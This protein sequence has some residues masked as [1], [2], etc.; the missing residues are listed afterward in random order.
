MNPNYYIVF[1][2]VCS[3]MM[4]CLYGLNHNE[5][6]PITIIDDKDFSKHYL[7][8][9]IFNSIG[10]VFVGFLLLKFQEKASKSESKDENINNNK[11]NTKIKLIYN[12]N[13]NEFKS[14]KIIIFYCLIILCWVL[15]DDIIENY[16]VIFQDLDFWMIELIILSWLSKKMFKYQLYK[17]HLLSISMCIFSSLLKVGC[18][19]ITFKNIGDDNDGKN[20]NGNLPIFYSFSSPLNNSIRIILAITFYFLLI[21]I[22]SYISLKLKWLMEKKIFLILNYSLFM[23]FQV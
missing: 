21:F 14:M 4:N 17:H 11:N 10:V 16:I 23:E 2:I 9:R 3:I 7:I 20:Y 18:I 8:H 13:E 22:R 19:F 15:I 12:D 1:M 5:S 6:F